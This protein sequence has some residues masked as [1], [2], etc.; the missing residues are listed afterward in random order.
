M[1]EDSLIPDA[2]EQRADWTRR[3]AIATAGMFLLSSAFPVIAGLSK[4]TAFFPRWFGILD[5][6][7]AF[8][9]AILAMAVLGVAQDKVTREETDA[10]YRAYRI[11]I[12]GILAMCVVFFIMGDRIVWINCL[13]GF[14][15]RAWLLLYCLPAWLAAF[16][17]TTA[18]SGQNAHEGTGNVA[19]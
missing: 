14:A 19:R 7:L 13:T 5:V 16:R 1:Q 15:W 8:V 11:M 3:L 10:S 9:L 2:V 17:A 4:D 18:A 12:H 6:C